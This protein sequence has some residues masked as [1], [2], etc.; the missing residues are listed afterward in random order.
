MHPIVLCAFSRAIDHW[1]NDGRRAIATCKW[2]L[3]FILLPIQVNGMGAPVHM[4]SLGE[5]D[6]DC[7]CV[8]A[9]RLPVI[10]EITCTHSWLPKLVKLRTAMNETSE[11][12]VLSTITLRQR[13]FECSRNKLL[14]FISLTST[15]VYLHPSLI[16]PLK[17]AHFLSFLARQLLAVARHQRRK[18]A[19]V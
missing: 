17:T 2:P 15:G 14:L 3:H 8:L 18:R 16:A 12:F 6:K 4:C 11:R 5:L 13:C 9:C 19:R 1:E 10:G 7:W